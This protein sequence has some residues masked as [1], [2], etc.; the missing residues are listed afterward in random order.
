[1]SGMKSEM[2]RG[3]AIFR[4]TDMND[5]GKTGETK[6]SREFLSHNVRE[7]NLTTQTLSYLQMSLEVPW[8]FPKDSD[9]PRNLQWASISSRHSQLK[10][11]EPSR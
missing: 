3:H 7:L 1:M 5:Y 6:K 11:G 10:R 8:H 4:L 9:S 2:Q